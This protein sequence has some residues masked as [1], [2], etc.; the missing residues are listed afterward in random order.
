MNGSISWRNDVQFFC[1][2]VD[3]NGPCFLAKHHQLLLLFVGTRYIL[4]PC[5]QLCS[6]TSD[7]FIIHFPGTKLFYG[8]SS[9][10]DDKYG[11]GVSTYIL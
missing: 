11:D 5:Q 2:I 1:M 8:R 3:R 4:Q 10:I 6:P 7:T 9:Q